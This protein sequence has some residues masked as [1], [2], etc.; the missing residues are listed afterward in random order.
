MTLPESATMLNES[1]LALGDTATFRYP[2][3]FIVVRR[4]RS[5]ETFLDMR[6]VDVF[7]ALAVVRR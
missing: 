3:E 5:T 2:G 4:D 1:L 6:Y 7:K